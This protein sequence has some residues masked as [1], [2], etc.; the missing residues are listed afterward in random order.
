MRTIWMKGSVK[1]TV[2][3]SGFLVVSAIVRTEARPQTGAGEARA[4]ANSVPINSDDIGG[5]VTSFERAR[6]RRVGHRR[7]H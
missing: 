5:V 2:L 3:L 7:N 6:S 4:E 1:L